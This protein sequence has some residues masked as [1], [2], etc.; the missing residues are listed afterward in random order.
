MTG[1]DMQGGDDKGFG[2]DMQGEKPDASGGKGG[3]MPTGGMQ[4]GSAPDGSK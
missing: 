4:G 2:G 1:G 3:E